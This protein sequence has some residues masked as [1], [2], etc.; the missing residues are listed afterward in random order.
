[1][2]YEPK[3][4]HGLPHNPFNALIAP[5]PIA[6]ISTRSDSGTANL[7]PYSFFNGVS[8]EPPQIMFASTSAKADQDNTKDTVANIRATGCFAVNL[9]SYDLRDAMNVTSEHF[10]KDTDEFARAGLTPAPCSAIDCPRVAEAPATLECRLV[11]ITRLPGQS[12]YVVFGEV[13]GVHIDDTILKDGMVDVTSFQLLSRLGYRDYT[14]VTEA[15]TL[16]R[17]DD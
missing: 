5:R 12:N 13:V 3:N 15:F 16:A 10:D 1:M 17:P 14:R 6:W 8:Y 9:V 2:Y 4:G 7:A 11:Q